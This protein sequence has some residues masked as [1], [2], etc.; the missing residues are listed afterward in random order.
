[1]WSGTVETKNVKSLERSTYH[2]LKRAAQ[3]AANLHSEKV[4][5]HGLTQRQYAVLAAVDENEG[6]SQTSL[7]EL[8]SIDRS[9][10]ADMV[11]RLIAQGY[12]RRKRDKKDARRNVLKLTAAGKRGLQTVGPDIASVDRKLT[13]L[14]PKE[15]RKSFRAALK[16][17]AGHSNN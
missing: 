4:G 2:L 11:G 17:L 5:K 15:H 16:I 14:I 7:V 13:H 3:H 6:I 1:M 9:T 12:V 10:L 8:T